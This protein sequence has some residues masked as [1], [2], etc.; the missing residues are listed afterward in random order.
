M[1]NRIDNRPRVQRARPTP[2]RIVVRPAP[3]KVEQQRRPA[4]VEAQQA[5]RAIAQ[6]REV[7][8]RGCGQ[9]PPNSPQP[10]T[11]GVRAD[12]VR[13]A[14]ARRDAQTQQAIND[15]KD[16]SRSVD[17]ARGD[18]DAARDA[19]VRASEVVKDS[20]VGKSPAEQRKI[21]DSVGPELT[22]ITRG[23]D[24]LDGD[25]TKQA[26]KNLTQAGEAVGR[27]NV[28][29]LA[30]PVAEGLGDLYDG[31]GSND[32]E[33][34]DGI[35]DAIKAGD[36]ALFGAALATNAPERA[37]EGITNAVKDGI[38]DVREDFGDAQDKVDQRNG[39]LA[40]VSKELMDE[41]VS[42]DAL[43][44]GA[45]A[46][47]REHQ[48]D[49]DKGAQRAR[50]AASVLDGAGL[51]SQRTTGDAREA[52]AK[53]LGEVHRIATHEVG[54]QAI[55]R[56]LTAETKGKPSFLDDAQRAIA[57]MPAGEERT[58]ATER[59]DGAVFQGASLA[60]NERLAENDPQG[61]AALTRA[62]SRVISDETL[63]TG[64]SRIGTDLEQLP[65]GE[66]VDINTARGLAASINSTVSS[67]AKEKVIR[68]LGLAGDVGDDIVRANVEDQLR[69]DPKFQSLTVFG[70]ALSV[71]GLALKGKAAID[72]P[73]VRNI[74]GLATAGTGSTE[75]GLGVARAFSATARG[76]AG[77]ASAATV[78]GRVNLAAAVGFSAIDTASAIKRGDAL[79]AGIAAAAILGAG[80]GVGV[81]IAGGATIGAALTGPAAPI[82]AAI[83]AIVG[84]GAGLIRNALEDSPEEKFRK[85]TQSFRD[86]A[87]AYQA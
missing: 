80:I 43:D 53:A 48:E 44:A 21:L 81:G 52:A 71:S 17:A 10:L 38:N 72:E 28:D 79:G 16:A 45:D 6:G 22:N 64:L 73:S 78:L 4:S 33:F 7:E 32:N 26:V 12:G 67:L 42:D 40:A 24:K 11:S 14:S 63:R 75:A 58:N 62:A 5:S 87:R 50:T 49:F 27:D 55:G 2:P 66:P 76:S 86:A 34:K 3:Q 13:E 74:V 8:A 9:T 51:L 15:I 61:A 60:A 37:R 70:A 39:E 47:R 31:H 83:G 57:R 36:G 25:Q 19:G 82:G 85:D 84:L 30:R 59:L 69:T 23:L 29:A 18:K 20:L 35:K 54:Q 46:F 41:G 68:D 65:Q 56:A 1:T 77:V